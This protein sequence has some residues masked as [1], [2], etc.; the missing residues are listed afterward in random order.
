MNYNIIYVK[1]IV[2]G[3]KLT[4]GGYR[5][6]VIYNLNSDVWELTN[7]DGLV[8]EFLTLERAI[9]QGKQDLNLKE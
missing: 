8:Q 1:G 2:G 7:T 5:C 3:F 6:S 4:K 9:Q